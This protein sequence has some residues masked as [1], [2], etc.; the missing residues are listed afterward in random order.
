MTGLR[1][2][3][4]WAAAAVA[5]GACLTMADVGA[6]VTRIEIDD[7]A[8][9]GTPFPDVGQFERVNG[10]A[11][12]ELD[13]F[14]RRNA[15]IQ[16]IQR[17]PRNASGKVEYIATFSLVKPIDMSK[18]SGLL[19]Y[20]V[21]NRG[22]S[23]ALASP[24]PEG[25]VALVSGWQG[26]VAPT[27]S[28]QTI[29]VPIA[30]HSDGSPITG[31]VLVRFVNTSGSTS[32]MGNPFGG[33]NRYPPATLDTAQASLTSRT[34][35]KLSGG[36]SGPP[37]EIASAD[38]A[39]ADCR[40]VPFPGT[41]DPTRVCL[42]NDFDPTLLYELTFTGKEP[43]VLGIGYAATRDITAFFRYGLQDDAGTPNPIAGAITHAVG[44]GTSQSGNFVKSL[45]HLGFNEDESGRIVWDGAWPYIAARQNPMN[46]RFAIPGGAAGV[47][48]PGSEAV[49]WW[50]TWSDQ[51][52]NRRTASM[53]DRCRATRTCPK[54]FETFGATE[55]WDLRMS[56]GLVGTNAKHDIPLP[57]NIYRYYYPGT[58]HGGGGG[59]FNRVQTPPGG[60][61]L[62][63][64][65]NPHSDTQNALFVAFVDWV[66]HG[67]RPPAS[68]YPTLKGGLLVEPTKSATGFPTIPY[69]AMPADAPNGLVNLVL[70]YDFGSKFIYNDMS[71]VI[72]LQPPRIK[73]ALP[74]LVVR[75]DRD[76]NEIGGV[77]SVLHQAPLGTYLGWN[78]RA[79]GF[80]EGQICDFTGGYVPFAQTKAERLANGDP[81]PSLEERYG[82]QEGYNCVVQRAAT[83][84]VSERFLL[85][86]DADRLIDQAAQANVLPS[87]PGN[88]V[89]IG[90]CK[91]P[92]DRHRHGKESKHDDRH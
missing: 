75:T 21:V 50:H 12:G 58:S 67:A 44:R 56:P 84:A 55:F 6:R 54:I 31:P 78:I 30:V 83:Q 79:S 65:P 53:L 51:A 1:I 43:L 4:A 26:D 89:A 41:P 28:N 36:A 62:P 63:R 80:Y 81:R 88:S 77:P 87:D 92:R 37:T 34:F 85:A 59:G 8:P 33:P 86:A 74:T 60:C 82:S 9:T 16:D 3:T 24:G 57:S 25:H 42:R 40:T 11:F 7:R 14:D 23:T 20:R 47:N 17:A 52:R 48:E 19:D 64:N 45:I 71:G 38:W 22:N 72:T 35:E 69:P 10:R 76:G 5:A 68:R 90:L 18:A 39:F 13:P 91:A 73:Q 46:F 27:A 29:Q 70:D 66:M 2:R 61:A 15:I 49:L 32:T